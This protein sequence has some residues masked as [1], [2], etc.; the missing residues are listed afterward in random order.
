MIVYKVYNYILII[1]EYI[2]YKY[3]MLRERRNFYC[4]YILKRI[5]KKKKIFGLRIGNFFDEIVNKYK[6]T[7]SRKF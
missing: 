4:V 6:D 1:C 7:I 3:E 2:E 5:G